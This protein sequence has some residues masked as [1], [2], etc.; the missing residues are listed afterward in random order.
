MSKRKYGGA[1]WRCLDIYDRFGEESY[2]K[3]LFKLILDMSK[4]DELT[5]KEQAV[6]DTLKVLKK[7]EELATKK[8]IRSVILRCS[9][10][11]YDE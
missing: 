8:D 5:D 4:D 2:R 11:L 6:L 7:E 3:Y 10:R 9:A 1:V